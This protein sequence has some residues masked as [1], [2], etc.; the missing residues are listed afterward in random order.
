MHTEYRFQ[1]LI[2]RPEAEAKNGLLLSLKKSA[3]DVLKLI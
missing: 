1:A 3:N 2:E